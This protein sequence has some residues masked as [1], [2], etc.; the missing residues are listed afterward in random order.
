MEPEWH[1]RR[2]R[3]G[4][5]DRCAYHRRDSLIGSQARSSGCTCSSRPPCVAGQAEAGRIAVR[6]IISPEPWTQWTE[7]AALPS[8]AEGVSP[9]RGIVSILS[10]VS[11]D[12]GR[13]W[14]AVPRLAS[15]ADLVEFVA[16]VW[17]LAQENPD[18]AFWA[19]EFMES[20]RGSV[21][22]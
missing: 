3:I 15:R 6:P 12:S 17:P 20:G 22:A 14:K 5:P 8:P 11:K 18:V 10:I 4:W 1:G 2:A 7:W 16:D 19:R 9:G 13:T 21:P